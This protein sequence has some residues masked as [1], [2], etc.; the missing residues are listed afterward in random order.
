M[1]IATKRRLLMEGTA[2]VIAWCRAN[3][4]AVPTIVEAREPSTHGACAFYRNSVITIDVLACAA[5]GTGGRSWSYPG[6]TVDRTPYGVLAHELGHHVDGAHGPAGG[7]W[8]ADLRRIAAEEPL[9][10]YCPNVNEYFAELFRLFV[11]NPDLL[12]LIRPRT[13]AVLDARWVTVED[14][15]WNVVLADAPGGR[16]LNA[17]RR[18]VERAQKGERR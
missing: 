12:R 1:T 16:Q 2:L 17:A 15:P 5:I 9:T 14:R 4:V 18:K 6:Y 3:R 7:T 10:S 13:H 8:G 11:T